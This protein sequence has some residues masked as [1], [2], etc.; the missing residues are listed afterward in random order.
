VRRQGTASF[1]AT[2]G[3]YG[4]IIAQIPDVWRGRLAA[5]AHDEIGR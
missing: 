1:Q 4:M 2:A 5:A 3:P